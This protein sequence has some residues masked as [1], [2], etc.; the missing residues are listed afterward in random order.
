MYLRFLKALRKFFCDLYF[1]CVSSVIVPVFARKYLWSL[2]GV[3][4]EGRAHIGPGCYLNGRNLRLGKNVVFG[5]GV[6]I[7]CSSCVVI[8]D[9]VHVSS[10]VSILSATHQIMNSVYRRDTMQSDSLVTTVHRGCWLGSGCLILPGVTIGEGCVVGAGSVVRSDCEPN[11]L[12]AGIP[13][14]R[15]RDLPYE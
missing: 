11:G 5:Y 12:Y 7:D 10:R 9:G 1:G 3:K 6:Y 15:I 13:A 4:R 14:R 8:G 2:G